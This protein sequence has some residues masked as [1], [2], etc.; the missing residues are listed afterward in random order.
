MGDTKIRLRSDNE[1]IFMEL[2]NWLTR[3]LSERIE[4]DY[5]KVFPR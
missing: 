4:P 1:R 2:N 5:F 3:N